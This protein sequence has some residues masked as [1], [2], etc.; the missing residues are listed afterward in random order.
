[1]KP[2]LII[3]W[4]EV[5]DGVRNR[6]IVAA[7][8]LLVVFALSITHLGSAP[9]GD[10]GV[11]PLTVSIVSLSSL[12]VF[13]LPLLGL[14]LSYDTVVGEN[15]R[16]TLLLYLS[17]PLKRWQFLTGKFIGQCLIIA[18]AVLIGYGAAGGLIIAGLESAPADEI[19][20]YITM[21]ASSVLLGAAFI[22]IGYLISVVAGQ[23]GTAA[24][25]ALSVWLG[26]VL[27]YDALLLG[28]IVGD[29]GGRIGDGLFNALLLANPTDAYRLLNLTYFDDVAQFAGITG[30]A[31]AGNADLMQSLASIALWIVVPLAAALAVFARK[32]V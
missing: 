14:M 26:F 32:E 13:L 15:E 10:V 27:I 8:L 1:M 6:W 24:G 29:V 12:T 17:Y 16:G 4:Q 11:S 18:I 2:C 25:L 5:R 3:A 23:R 31:S 28:I 30:I 22:A 20:A 21:M 7:A 19:L 9:V